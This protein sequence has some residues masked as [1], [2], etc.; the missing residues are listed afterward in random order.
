[1][2][3]GTYGYSHSTR[4]LVT[5]P[6]KLE[7]NRFFKKRTR[8]LPPCLFP[9]YKKPRETS[10]K[11]ID[12]PLLEYSNDDLKN[13][14]FQRKITMSGNKADVIYRLIQNQNDLVIGNGA[15]SVTTCDDC[16]KAY[17]EYN[18]EESPLIKCRRCKQKKCKKCMFTCTKKLKNFYIEKYSERCGKTEYCTKCVND[19]S[20]DTKCRRKPKH[21][22]KTDLI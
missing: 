11:P 1:M 13:F 20:V 22:K 9:G 5:H 6:L 15:I 17:I 21:L 16:E 14:C 2:T 10:I 19:S 3:D 18:D 12:R 8:T 7:S 4:N